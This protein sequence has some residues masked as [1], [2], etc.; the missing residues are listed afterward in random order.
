ME[1]KAHAWFAL[2][3]VK[4]VKEDVQFGEIV[5]QSKY[6]LR[7]FTINFAGIYKFYI[8]HEGMVI[9]TSCLLRSTPLLPRPGMI[10]LI[11]SDVQVSYF[12]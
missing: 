1:C 4:L 7:Y 8:F 11:A 12:L 5:N 2:R 9:Q 10:V 6:K 3:K